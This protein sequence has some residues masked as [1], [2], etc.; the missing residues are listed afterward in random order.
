[1]H[2]GIVMI[3]T[4]AFPCAVLEDRAV[5]HLTITRDSEQNRV[6]RRAEVE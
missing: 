5:G 1:M 2:H 6:K 4:G 3:S